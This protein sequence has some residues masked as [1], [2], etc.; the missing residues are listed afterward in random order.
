M[1]KHKMNT[2]EALLI[3]LMESYAVPGY[4]LS[5]LEVQKL[6]Y[7]LQE[8]GEQMKLDFKK[9]KYGPYAEN[10]NHV[11]QRMEGHYIRGYGDRTREAEIYLVDDA[12]E[13]AKDFLQ[14]DKIVTERLKEVK[15]L[16]KGFEN[17]YGMELLSTVYWIMQEN[18]VK[19][20]DSNY[21]IKEVKNWN[22]RKKEIFSDHH[23]LKVWSYLNDQINS[24]ENTPDEPIL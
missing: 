21:V 24:H 6:A 19:S 4:R 3:A 7:I 17:P 12:A 1:E 15:S 22:P 10:L 23:I 8:T 5:H 2:H 13:K 18:L 14:N 11:L 9:Y 16:I 20:T